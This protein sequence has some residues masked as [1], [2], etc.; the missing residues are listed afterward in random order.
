[1][2][3]EALFIEEYKELKKENAKL[4]AE[5][6]DEKNE[7]DGL[8]ES[9]NEL[10]SFIRSLKPENR[11]GYND[12]QYIGFANGGVWDDDKFYSLAQRYIEKEENE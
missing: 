3:L 11:K 7:Y 1:M 10:E 4:K 6:E 8:L 9:K 12:R 2:N 5:L